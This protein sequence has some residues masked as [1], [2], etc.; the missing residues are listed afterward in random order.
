MI[1]FVQVVC[2]GGCVLGLMAVVRLERRRRRGFVLVL[3]RCRW[4]F[5]WRSLGWRDRSGGLRVRRPCFVF[6]RPRARTRLRVSWWRL[7]IVFLRA[8]FAAAFT[9]SDG[10]ARAYGRRGDNNGNSKSLLRGKALVVFVAVS[11]PAGAAT[12]V[13]AVVARCVA[14]PPSSEGAKGS[15]G[16][17][18]V[19]AQREVEDDLECKKF[20]WWRRPLTMRFS[21]LQLV[22]LFFTTLLLC[23]TPALAIKKFS[24]IK[25]RN[26]TQHIH[27]ILCYWK[28]M[29]AYTQIPYGREPDLVKT[30]SLQTLTL[31]FSDEGY[32]PVPSRWKGTCQDN[33]GVPC[34]RKLIGARYFNK[35]FIAYAAGLGID[36]EGNATY[37]SGRDSE[38][39]GSH[40]LSTA[41]GNFVEGV[42]VVGQGNGTAKGGS[43]RARVAAYKV[44]WP[45]I[46]GDG[47]CFDADTLQ[48]FDTAIHDGVDV[49]SL[50]VGGDPGDYFNDGIAIGSFHA[51][52]HGIVVV[53]SA[54]NDGPSPGTVSNVAPWILTVGASTIDRD[55]QAIVQLHNG[56]QLKGESL[57][58]LPLPQNT[59]YPL[60]TGAQAKSSNAS[61]EEGLLCLPKSLDPKKA[62][63]KIVVCLR[64]ISARVD[65]GNQ[66]A[67]AGAAGMILANAEADG[68]GLAA[69][70]HPA[71]SMASFSSVGPNTVTPE[72]IKPDITAPG[73]NIIAAYSEAASPT[74][75]DFDNRRIPYITESG[76]S[77][78]C[79]HVSGVAGLLKTLHP[80]WSPAAIRPNRAQDPGL[81]YDLNPTDYLDFLCSLGYNQSLIE[82]VAGGLYE[83]PES[84]SLLNFNYPSIAVPRLTHS[85][86]L[87]RKLKNVG[88]PGRYTARVTEPYG[89]SVIVDPKVLVFDKIGDE[90]SFTV[91]LEAKW[92]GAAKDYE[93]GH[94]IWADG[95]GHYARDAIFYSYTRHINGFAAMLEEEEAADIA[96]SSKETAHNTFMGFYVNGKEWRHTPQ[97]HM[98]ESQSFS[99]EGYGPVPSRWKGTCQNNTGGVGFPCNRK[100][101]GARFFNK[102]Y[103]AAL[104][105]NLVDNATYNSARDYEGHGSHTLST[106]GGNFV[107]GASVFG[108]GNGT[109][110]GGSPRA[111]VAAYKV[112]WPPVNDSECFDADI[113]QAFDMAIHDGVDVISV[114]LGGE[115]TDYFND[116]IAIGS[117]HAVKHGIVVVCSAGNSGPRPGTVSNVAPWMITVGASTTDRDFQTIVQLHNGKQLK[118]VSMSK[119]LPQH[120]SYPLITGAQ[121][122]SS[123]ASIEEGL[124]CLPK[125][126]DR[127]KAEGKIVV[128]LRG[129]TARLDKGNQA[130]L[131]GAVGM[132]LANDEADGN[133]VVADLHVLPASHINYKDGLALYAYI[134]STKDP[135]GY[136]FPPSTKFNVKPAPFMAAFSSIGPNTVTPEILKPDITAPGVSII[137]AYTGGASPTGFDFDHRRIPFLTESGTSMSCPHLASSRHSTLT[138]VLL[139]LARTRD[140][141]VNPMQ[142]GSSSEATPFDYGAGHIRPNRAQDPGLVYDL[143]ANDYTGF[144]C[145][146]G[147]NQT[148]IELFAGG[149][150]ECPESVSF[151][152]FNYPSIAVPRLTHSITL[153]RKLKNVGKPGRYAA[154]VIEPNGI[155]VIVDPNVLVFDKIGD[156]RSFT[157]TLEA[158]SAGAAK[159]YEFGHLIWADGK[160]HYTLL[161]LNYTMQM[162][163]SSSSSA[164]TLPINMNT[165]S[166]KL[167]SNIDVLSRRP[168]CKSQASLRSSFLFPTTIRALPYKSLQRLKC[169][170]KYSMFIG[171]K[172]MLKDGSLTV[173]GDQVLTGVP[174]NV[175]VT[176]LTDSSAFLGATATE[177]S[178]RHGYKAL[179][180]VSVQNVV[181]DTP[182]GGF[183]KILSELSGTFAVRESKQAG[184]TTFCFCLIHQTPGILDWF[185]WCTW[186]AF[187]H[188]V[189]PQGIKEGLKSLSD[190][191][192]PAKFL[193]IDDGWQDTTNDFQKGAEP[194]VEGF[195]GRLVTIKENHKFRR[196]ETEAQ[197][198]A[199]TGLKHFVSDFKKNF[200]LKYVYVW[201]ALLGY[202]GGLV[203]DAK[204]TKM[205]NAK[206]T[207]P[208]QSPGN[209]ANVRD[210]S[211]DCM[212]KYGIGAIDPAR[213]SQFYDDL[214]GYLVSQDVDGVK[215]DVQNILETIASGQGGRVSLTRHF[216]QELEKSIAA[217]FKDN[218]II[219]CM[220]LS[221]DSIYHSKRSAIT[222]AS[223][224]YWPKNPSTQT[225][226]IAA[227]AFNS[228]FLGEVVVPDWD[229]KAYQ[230]LLVQ[231]SSN[232]WQEIWNLNKC[233]GVIGVFNCQ[234]AGTWPLMEVAE[235]TDH[236]HHQEQVGADQ[237]SGTVSPADVEYLE[238]ASGE[239]WTGDCAV[240]SFNAGS[241]SRIPK[242][243]SFDVVLETLQCQ[244]FTIS[245]VKVYHKKIEFAAIGLI[246]MYNSGGAV[247]SVGD[248]E[249]DDDSGNGNG[250]GIHIKGKGAGC[251][252][253]YSTIIPKSCLINSED[254]EFTFRDEDNLLTIS[255]P[256]STTAS[257]AWDIH[258]RY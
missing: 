44:C 129:I 110:K 179:V 24:R 234:G 39:H 150:Y 70:L 32:G 204:G 121:A 128:C 28:R 226:H 93:F 76:T 212:E 239:L 120:K 200:G 15:C 123:N 122:K 224:D 16:G 52:K 64:G 116:G 250:T 163:L 164:V 98:E 195:G 54:G 34:N 80:D 6:L 136:I 114:S 210:L 106:A 157:V 167:N 187:Y 105:L 232:G 102:G 48:A 218:S 126:L 146:L 72:I 186:D 160:G 182:S 99:D 12:F 19:A 144:L 100:L 88:K 67:L 227:V 75:S 83:C 147:Y 252:G 199:A 56:K 177:Y 223:D 46:V 172:P 243:G 168:P 190:G 256:P 198:N 148:L 257:A 145:S 78:S 214:H 219:C 111:R 33:V 169:R 43:P 94:L 51:V 37:N 165:S 132:I 21:T 209:L 3:P 217:N 194:F 196:T 17:L 162:A 38:G 77:M 125:S 11:S 25:Q 62:E 5:A 220:G 60:I 82:L 176:P 249:A 197:N 193:I 215:V 213:I 184:Q 188:G 142:T 135:L 155:S 251:F 107:E 108:L 141:T 27:G 4:L 22:L 242:E 205:Y 118:G 104:G 158:R 41:G 236:H 73:V 65:K 124:L 253:A 1:L 50:S 231:R 130:A 246:N 161:N 8:A 178:S 189:N 84:V 35:A 237:I 153:T 20:P 40:T 95:K 181:D 149:P 53:S 241:L 171:T 225:L 238:E 173:N 258:I 183:S 203:P 228:I 90:R 66:A 9:F 138:G 230:R 18:L 151:L 55:F 2:G 92:P 86:T 208:V 103:S 175:C 85:I 36:L 154:R 74:E 180:S 23:Q 63:G 109:A 221:T 137:A 139:R 131:A 247:E 10:T 47:E 117:F 113:L 42:N 30:P 89:I 7:E 235:D 201:H 97:F 133:E 229:M 222:R 174:D 134:K 79:P 57:S 119:P 69:D 245:P 96:K 49:I 115:P 244:V 58:N 29:A 248:A 13:A 255:I 68:N 156:E 59:S 81:V 140:N 71:P 207:Y 45:K 240:Y 26:C 211:M 206:L 143:N 192:T 101:I 87:T 254:A 202:W 112:C 91:T 166:M 159:D 185:G 233:T 170:W 216:Q 127:K 61:V 191:G 31:S 14:A 152:N